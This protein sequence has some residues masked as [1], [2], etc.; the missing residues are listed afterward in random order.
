[1][2]EKWKALLGHVL[3]VNQLNFQTFEANRPL[4]FLAAPN[5]IA[6]GNLRNEPEQLLLFSLFILLSLFF[7]IPRML[8]R[9]MLSINA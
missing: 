9:S 2:G 5:V 7:P 6:S 8:I 1:M 4:T 3:C